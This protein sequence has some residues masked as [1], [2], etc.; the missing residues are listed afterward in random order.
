MCDII[1]RAKIPFVLVGKTHTSLLLFKNR[2]GTEILP[3]WPVLDWSRNAGLDGSKAPDQP[4]NP[5]LVRKRWFGWFKNAW[6]A[7]K[8]QICLETLDSTVQRHRISLKIPDLSWN[9]NS[10]VQRRQIG[11]ILCL[12]CYFAKNPLGEFSPVLRGIFPCT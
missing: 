1:V 11:I 6:S 12:V 8:S 3:D 4:K 9:P 5:G 2:M 7:L 10:T